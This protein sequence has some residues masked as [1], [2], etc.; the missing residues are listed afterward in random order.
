L[1]SSPIKNLELC[2]CLHE[3]QD[4]CY[5]EKLFSD[6]TKYYTDYKLIIIIITYEING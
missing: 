5:Q 2:S 1:G 4:A 6:A 3:H